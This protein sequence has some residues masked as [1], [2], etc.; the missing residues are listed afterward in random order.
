M[1]AMAMG[2][3]VVASRITGVPELV[4]EGRSGLLV[5]PGR[6][7][8][9]ADS[10]AQILSAEREKRRTMGTAGRSRVRDEF[11]AERNVE[12]LLALFER[13]LGYST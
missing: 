10:L 3:P 8:A 7:D 9:L 12:R 4:E 1:E 5:P 2:L 6:P 11:S 13:G